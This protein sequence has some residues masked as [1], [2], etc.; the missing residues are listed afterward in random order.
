MHCSS[1]QILINLIIISNYFFLTVGI[2]E[3]HLSDIHIDSHWNALFS[4]SFSTTRN[5]AA[6]S[7]T[8]SQ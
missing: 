5:L 2:A 3:F 7:V 8:S 4:E 1:M 6:W